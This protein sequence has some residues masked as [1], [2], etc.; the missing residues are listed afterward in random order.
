[1]NEEL[2]KLI[3]DEIAFLDR[4]MHIEDLSINTW[5]EVRDRKEYLQGL[6]P[7]DGGK[8]DFI[9]DEYAD[10]YEGSDQQDKDLL[11]KLLVDDARHDCNYIPCPYTASVVSNIIDALELIHERRNKDR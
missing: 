4:V 3:Q 1:M 5:Y 9:N 10:A 2:E 8:A 6:L 11:Y 7:G